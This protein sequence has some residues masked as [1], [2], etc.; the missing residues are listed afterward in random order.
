MTLI[1]P[2]SQTR[3]KNGDKLLI[4]GEIP[5]K[6]IETYYLQNEFTTTKSMKI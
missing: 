6:L 2:Y 1:Y 4:L 3:I 5:L